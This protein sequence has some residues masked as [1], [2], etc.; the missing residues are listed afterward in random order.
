MTEQ[1]SRPSILRTLF[2][3]AAVLAVLAL[4]VVASYAFLG[5]S[6]STPTHTM[7]NGQTMNTMTGMEM[8]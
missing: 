6:T 5:S 4:A 7:S 3:V 8:P 2:L 1:P